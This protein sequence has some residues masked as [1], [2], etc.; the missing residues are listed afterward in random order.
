M[1]KDIV[2]AL[3]CTKEFL[4]S[5]NQHCSRKVEELHSQHLRRRFEHLASSVDE[6]GSSGF[7]FPLV[8]EGGDWSCLRERELTLSELFC[9]FLCHCGLCFGPLQFCIAIFLVLI[10][11]SLCFSFAHPLW[12]RNTLS[13]ASI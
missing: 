13:V 8:L 2:T 6:C 9:S 12:Q 1:G 3:W 11:S 5:S 10:A 4:M 7:F